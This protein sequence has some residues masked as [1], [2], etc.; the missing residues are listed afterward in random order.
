MDYLMSLKTNVYFTCTALLK[1]LDRLM[2]FVV[3]HCTARAGTNTWFPSPLPNNIDQCIF[4]ME[5]NE[6]VALKIALEYT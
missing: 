4:L 3:P 5:K 6:R 1:W 2:V